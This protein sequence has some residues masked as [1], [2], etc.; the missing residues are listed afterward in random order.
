[1]PDDP[2]RNPY[3]KKARVDHPRVQTALDR[4][5]ARRKKLR[6]ASKPKLDRVPI[7]MTPELHRL[8]R[9]AVDRQNRLGV[10]STISTVVRNW[11][12]DGLR[13]CDT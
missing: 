5:R 9:E 6:D 2:G 3:R 12:L 10:R 13:R 7:Q 4:Q 8:V 11:I 1:M